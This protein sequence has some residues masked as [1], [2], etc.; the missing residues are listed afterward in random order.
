PDYFG[1]INNLAVIQADAGQHDEAVAT[2]A[3]Y[4]AF[5]HDNAIANCNYANS[6]SALGRLDEA[7]KHYRR[8]LARQPDFLDALINFGTQLIRRDNPK[9]AMPYFQRAY[10]LQPG[11]FQANNN[12]G[13]AYSLLGQY[14]A[15]QYHLAQA[16]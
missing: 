4:L 12:V 9:E 16:V 3:K 15:A 1:A 2:I 10:E 8:A 11:S 6:L 7:A 5:D 14:E 13:L